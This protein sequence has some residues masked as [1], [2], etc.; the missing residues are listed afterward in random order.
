ME[1]AY[2]VNLVTL[3]DDLVFCHLAV[4]EPEVSIIYSVVSEFLAR[5]SCGEIVEGNFTTTSSLAGF[6]LGS[7]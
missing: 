3:H 6:Q 5:A 1:G 2:L 4:W 7:L